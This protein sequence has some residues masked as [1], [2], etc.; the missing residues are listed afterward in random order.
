MK[1]RSRFTVLF[2]ILAAAAVLV[3]VL[4]SDATVGRAVEDRVAERFRRDLEHLVEDLAGLPEA[5]R[6]A[7]LRNAAR[8]LQNRITLIAPD[9]KVLVDTDLLPQDVSA[10]ENHGNRPEFRQALTTG[11]GEARRTSVTEGQRMLYEA[12]RVGNGLVLR[13]AASEAHLREVEQKYLWT[14]RVAI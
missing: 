4:V 6:D 1:P 12:R 3:L 13:L 14:M 2:A 5:S 10:M 9:G 7:F 8:Q 11:T